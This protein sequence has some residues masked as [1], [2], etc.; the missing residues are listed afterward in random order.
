M[1]LMAKAYRHELSLINDV[2]ESERKILLEN[3][4]EKWEAL[5]KRLQ[6]DNLVGLD[7]RKE[8]MREYEKEM[9]KVIIEHQEEFRAQKISFELEIEKLR[10]E[11]QSTKALCFINIEKL[12][13]SYAVLKQREDENTIVKN[14]QKR[15]INKSVLNRLNL[16]IDKLII[17]KQQVDAS[18]TDFKMLSMV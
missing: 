4:M 6:E 7:R 18:F 12:D 14:Q 9:K 13:Y 11:V 15:R 17:S 8:I 10:Q 16:E 3:M 2:I 5:Y 1:N